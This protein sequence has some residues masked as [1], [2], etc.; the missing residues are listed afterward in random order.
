MGKVECLN[1]E[2]YTIKEFDNL[3]IYHQE[4]NLEIIETLNRI[5]CVGRLFTVWIDSTKPTTMKN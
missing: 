2:K 3:Q 5:V 1:F 4:K